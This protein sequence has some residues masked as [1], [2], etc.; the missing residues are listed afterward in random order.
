AWSPA[1]GAINECLNTAV[2][3]EFSEK[4]DANSVMNNVIL[5]RKVLNNP[6]PNC[7]FDGS[8]YWC[9]VNASYIV[10][11]LNLD[12]DPADETEVILNPLSLLEA[13]TEYRAIVNKDVASADGMKLDPAWVTFDLD[14]DG[15]NDGFSWSFTTGDKVCKIHRASISPNPDRFNC[16]S[17]NCPDDAS[18]GILG[19]QHEYTAHVYDIK[20]QE[21]NIAFGSL[22]KNWVV[23]GPL[24]TLVDNNIQQV[25]ATAANDNGTEILTVKIK[26]TEANPALNIGSGQADA[27]VELFMCELPWPGLNSYPWEDNAYNFST[28]YCRARDANDSRL[29]LLTIPIPKSTGDILREY[30]F[31]V[32]PL[33]VSNESN[34]NLAEHKFGTLAINTE[35]DQMPEEQEKEISWWHKLARLFS[36]NIVEGEE[37]PVDSPLPPSNLTF[38]TNA[39]NTLT[40]Y[41]I[42]DSTNEDG[43][44]IERKQSLNGN[45]QKIATAP[46]GGTSYIDNNVVV[47]STYY[48][49][50]FAYANLPGIGLT[51]SAVSSNEVAVANFA[52]PPPNVVDVIGIRVMKNNDHLSVGDW[53]KQ[54]APNP[55]VAGREF[56]LD[57][58]EALQVGNTIYISATNLLN[59]P[60]RLYTNI[61]II[62][63]NIGAKPYTADI[64]SQMVDNFKLNINI[65]QQ[66]NVCD[67]D[68]TVKCSSDFDCDI[69]NGDYCKSM[70]LKLRRDLVRL[71]DLV[72]IKN[73]IEDYGEEHKACSNNAS[74][75]CDNNAQCPNNG[76]CVRYYPLLNAG[77]FVPGMSTSKWP[78]SWD[79]T[80]KADLNTDLPKDPIN[81]FN[82]CPADFDPET[83]WNE[84]SREFYCSR[85]SLLYVYEKL[86]FG[87]DYNLA[88]NFEYDLR[89]WA[90][91]TFAN[92]LVDPN[93]SGVNNAIPHLY[94]DLSNGNHNYCT[95]V[96]I[97]SD[98]N[99]NNLLCGNGLVDPNF[100]CAGYPEIDNAGAC[101]AAGGNWRQEECDGGL[102]DNM[103]ATTV[104][105]LGRKWWDEVQLGCNPPGA[106]DSNG[107][108]IECTWYVPTQPLTGEQCGGYCGDG[109]LQ[110]SYE[111][112][113]GNDFNNIT[114]SC[115]FNSAPPVFCHS[116][117]CQ[118]VC[119]P[120]PVPAL[121]CNDSFWDEDRG[122]VCDPS[123]NPNGLE[124]WSCTEGGT[125]YCNNSCQMLCTVGT[126]YGGACGDGNL[127]QP[128]EECDYANYQ[129][130]LP[131]D[132][133]ITNP[134]TCSQ[135]C[136]L[137]GQPY[138]GDDTQQYDLKELCDWDYIRPITKE[139]SQTKQYQCRLSNCTPTQGGYCGDG[140]VQPPIATLGYCSGTNI[141]CNNNTPCDVNHPCVK[142][143]NEVCDTN[144][145][146]PLPENSSDLIQYECADDCLSATAGGWCGDK[147][148]HDGSLFFGHSTDYGEKC[149][150]GDAVATN[151]C[152]NM[153][154]WNC[155]ANFNG[156]PN[157]PTT[158]NVTFD[159]QPTVTLFSGDT[160][161]LNLPHC[162]VSG[163][164]L[165][166][167]FVNSQVNPNETT[168]IV[169]ITDLSGSMK[170]CLNW[171]DQPKDPNDPNK[172][173]D[174]PCPNGPSRLDAIKD[175][176]TKDGGF[177]DTLN[178]LNPD[179]DL[180]FINFANVGNFLDLDTEDAKNTNRAHGQPDFVKVSDGLDP[181]L[182]IKIKEWVNAY[183]SLGGT[184]HEPPLRRAVEAF[185]SA[186]VE[187]D[188]KIVIFLTDGGATD[189]VSALSIAD[190]LKN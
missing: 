25:R 170:W 8:S 183:T 75:G 105:P 120:G 112:C 26:D 185:Y 46:R 143:F 151:A 136:S 109:R 102:R 140:A 92:N 3:V 43:F 124:D 11:H 176:L 67:D 60:N 181:N 33:V 165:T 153:C 188:N 149:D 52:M 9:R 87:M 180:T 41:W 189:S 56:E 5:Y 116:A 24:L 142:Y 148:V 81:I 84:T 14:S 34:S 91:V 63:Y 178:S 22:T 156:D 89:N 129:T 134:Y 190:D 177:L 162:R 114:Y 90:G 133:S 32:D 154:Q 37:I 119:N 72:A 182:G 96:I 122:E 71:T 86:N 186:A 7:V 57:G 108:L 88:S 50:V 121:A 65:P 69:D 127:D 21:L 39:N 131:E 168:G 80:L 167:V 6:P 135:D 66:N 36:P 132:S 164:V 152:N 187:Y 78:L 49:R 73:A 59:G 45:W 76:N 130:P 2:T 48:Y 42:D 101:W 158:A 29:P 174:I 179:I 20:G 44:S 40:L 118:P 17:N 93:G 77:S 12:I 115:P 107:N 31:I 18:F 166:D 23:L 28:Y 147:I 54:H 106:I 169:I 35:A 64:F 137:A 163:D 53:Y 100:Y 103:C 160:A 141:P 70:N 111:F 1:E 150:D 146:A 161:T 16:A 58:Y 4:M 94:A 110:L 15:N 98:G 139:S 83:C 74:V 95:D 47:G 144:Y 30:V 113:E 173:L 117:T 104:L 125:V 85:N 157:N 10:S 172:P 123:G 19:N 184:F 13:N 79:T 159:G 155:L 175:V 99:P 51:Y 97:D 138:C 82:G 55:G 145:V 61:Y 126:P 27:R 62:A 68:N 171:A 128:E 38:V